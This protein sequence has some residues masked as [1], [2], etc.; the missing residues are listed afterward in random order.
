MIAAFFVLVGTFSVFGIWS[1]RFPFHGY[2]VWADFPRTFTKSWIYDRGV[3]RFGIL[4]GRL[5]NTWIY[6]RDGLRSLVY[7]WEGFRFMDIWS[8]R[9]PFRENPG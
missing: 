9:F 6:D 7:D 3:F 8:G 5:P 2:M 1:G 4:P